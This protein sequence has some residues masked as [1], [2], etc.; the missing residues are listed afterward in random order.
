MRMRPIA[1]MVLLL[2]LPYKT[3]AKTVTIDTPSLCT[4]VEKI[5]GNRADLAE[6]SQPCPVEGQGKVSAGI[7]EELRDIHVYVNGTYWKKVAM[8]S[9]AL[10]AEDIAETVA[11]SKKHSL[12]IDLEEN[13]H[14]TEATRLA[15][16][17]ARYAQSGEFQERIEA[18]KN[19]LYGQILG[20][21]ANRHEAAAKE[22]PGKRV[23]LSS[24]ERIYLFISAS[25]PVP[26]LRH[27]VKVISDLGEP[28]IRI[29]IQGFVGGAKF[30]KPTMAFLK[31]ILFTDPECNPSRERCKV[32][33]S[34]VTVDPLLFRKYRIERVPA[35][36][37][38]PSLSISDSQMSEGLGSAK[39]SDHYVVYGDMSLEYALQLFL[40]EQKSPGLEGV[41]V[42]C[43]GG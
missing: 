23:G 6:P 9:P 24:R 15:E 41:L 40:R 17:L 16:D 35:F 10:S 28:N 1:L 33:S 13:P 12:T 34:Q 29:V 14:K 31:E 39:V 3:L 27:Y 25:V 42:G 36:V 5:E 30:L 19:R 32:Y 11:Q 22:P 2:A 26:T 4:R 7:K 37:Y 8:N 43:R 20:S 38:A 21:Q 18:Q